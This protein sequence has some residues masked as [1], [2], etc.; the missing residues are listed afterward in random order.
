MPGNQNMAAYGEK[1]EDWGIAHLSIVVVGAS[2]AC[3]CSRASTIG[4]EWMLALTGY[5]C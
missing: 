2:G 1:P 4:P 5:C 3:C